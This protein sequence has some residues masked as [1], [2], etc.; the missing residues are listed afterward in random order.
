MVK[1][2]FYIYIY[3]YIIY[4]YIYI[5]YIYGVNGLCLTFNVTELAHH[6]R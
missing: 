1:V 3:I 4:I 5:I 6:L 2:F